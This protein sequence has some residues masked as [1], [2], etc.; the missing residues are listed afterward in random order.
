ML[1]LDGR[2]SASPTAASPARRARTTAGS[3]P[4]ASS[5][6]R[7]SR[8]TRR[9][10]ST[11]ASRISGTNAEVMPGQWEFQIGPVGA[12]EVGDQLYVAR[13]LL[14]RIAEDYDVVVTFDAKPTKGDWNGAGATPTSRPR[15]CVRATS[16]IEKACKALG[17]NGDLHV[18]N[19]GHGIEEPPHGQAR[20]GPWNEFSYGVSDRGASIRIPWQVDKDGKGYIEDRRPNANMDPYMVARLMVETVC[21]SCARATYG[22]GRRRA[23]AAGHPPAASPIDEPDQTEVDEMHRPTTRLRLAHGGGAR[24]AA[25]PPVVHRRP[26]QPEELRHQPGRA[27][28]RPRRRDDLRR[29]V[30]RRLLPRPGERRARRPR[31]QHVRAVALGRRRTRPRRG[32]SATSP[33]STARRS[34]ATP[35]RCCG[36]TSTRP[37]S[38]GFTFYVAPDMEFFY[39]A[40]PAPRPAAAAARRGLVLRP[41]DH[42]RRRRRCASRRS[43]RSRRWASRSSTRF[44]EDAPSQHEID[45]RHTDA[46]TMADSV[47]TFRLVVKEVAASPGRARHVHAQAAR[48]RAGLGHAHPPRRCSRATRTRSSTATTPTTCPRWPSASSPA[49]C[50]TPPRSPRS[51]TRPSTPT[52]GSCP[53]FEA[54]VHIIVGP[55]Q[56]HRPGPGAD[57][58]A[59]NPRPPASSTG[60]PIR[61]ATRTSRSACILAAGMRG[62]DEGYELA[63]EADGQPVRDDR[64]GARQARHRPAAPVAVRGAAR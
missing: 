59:G 51:R 29:L 13:W 36:A 14:H 21:G 56:P 37:A 16:A 61:P 7:S 18:K 24:R 50:T 60:R 3:A 30:D 5:G 38:Q 40:P 6:A 47:M 23:G 46:L 22:T 58:Q 55:Q 45:L 25:D 49:C 54:P 11:P 12:V 27:R 34:T 15:R 62:I 48:G 2:R 28:E 31:P 44:H 41:H 1:K 35:A 52:S 42:R 63:P 20:D 10:A 33:T 4:T 8:P 57:R 26:R 19:Y 9:R 43:T 39:F 32:C 53:G 64:R 17:K